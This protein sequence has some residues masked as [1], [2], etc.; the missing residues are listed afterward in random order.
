MKLALYCKLTRTSFICKYIEEACTFQG[1]DS[2]YTFVH[3]SGFVVS[4]IILTK[5]E[6][7]THIASYELQGTHATTTPVKPTTKTNRVQGKTKA[8]QS[9]TKKNEQTNIQ[10]KH[11][12]AKYNNSKQSKATQC[13]TQQRTRKQFV[14]VFFVF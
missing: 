11:N 6:P 13:K 4:C 9:T 10:S 2:I 7:Y 12:N 1:E 8:R 5:D 3:T 14:V